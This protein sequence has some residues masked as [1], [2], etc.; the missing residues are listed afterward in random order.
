MS[1]FRQLSRTFRILNM[2]SSQSEQEEGILKKDLNCIWESGSKVVQI[3]MIF[4]QNFDSS[5]FLP[6][7]D[8]DRL[9]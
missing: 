6:L 1:I 8:I 9:D 5:L 7:T 3:K 2:Y 4:I